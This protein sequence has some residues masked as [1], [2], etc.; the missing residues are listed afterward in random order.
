MALKKNYQFFGVFSFSGFLLKLGP[1]IDLSEKKKLVISTDIS[2]N[3]SPE[4]CEQPR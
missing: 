4:P 3:Q 2:L 1:A